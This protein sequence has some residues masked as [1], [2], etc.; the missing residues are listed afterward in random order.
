M[1]IFLEEYRDRRRQLRVRVE[2]MLAV[3]GGARAAT[4][5]AQ[6][7]ARTGAPPHAVSTAAFADPVMPSASE[8]AELFAS[9]SLI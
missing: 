5:V 9:A 8:L 7:P 2:P 6:S 4:S 1:L 3:A